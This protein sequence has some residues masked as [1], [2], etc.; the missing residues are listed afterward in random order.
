[1]ARRDTGPPDGFASVVLSL[2]ALMEAGAGPEAVWRALAARHPT[3]P[4]VARVA[5]GGSH[6]RVSARIAD[7]LVAAD[8]VDPPYGRALVAPAERRGWRDIAA[9]M[10]VVEECGAP[11]GRA[12]GHGA[13]RSIDGIEEARHVQ[14]ALASARMTGRV[15]SSL[16]LVSVLLVAL[17]GVN[18]VSAAMHSPVVGVSLL[19]AGALS[20][21]SMLWRGRLVARAVRPGD[22]GALMVRLVAVAVDAGVS[23][24][25]ALSVASA[26]MRCVEFEGPAAARIV[27]ADCAAGRA[28]VEAVMPLVWEVGAP[29]GRILSAEATRIARAG[30]SDAL[31]RAA[32]L[33][34]GQLAPLGVCDLPAFFLAGVVPAVISLLS[35]R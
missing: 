13:A 32:A 6:R 23:V 18:V 19:A 14:R 5:A 24:S 28:A 35:A 16:P 22:G 17:L 15:L 2:R 8:L 7:A 4:V 30:H 34:A 3:D 27:E 20:V 1:M 33:E 21:G 10:Y 31:R 12:L 9:L 25:A 29:L 11:A 26:A